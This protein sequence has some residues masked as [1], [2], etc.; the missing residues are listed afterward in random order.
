MEAE[1]RPFVNAALLPT[2]LS[3]PLENGR[4]ALGA[5]QGIYLV[6]HRRAPRRREIVLALLGA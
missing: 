2:Q 5:W 4:L 1:A 3:I 6:E